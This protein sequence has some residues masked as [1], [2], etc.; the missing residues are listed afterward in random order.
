MKKLIFPL[1]IMVILSCLV[2]AQE[3][4]VNV[5]DFLE[6]E[7]LSFKY[8]S[9][10]VSNEVFKVGF[11]LMNSGSLDYRARVRL[12]IM[13]DT[14]L[15][16]TGWSEEVPLWP[17]QSEYFELYWYPVNI[18]G[19]LTGKI[20]IYH[21]NEIKEIEPFK[22]EIKGITT[23][24]K[25]IQITGLRTYEDRVEVSIR[26]NLELKDIIIIPSDYPYG[27]IFEQSKIDSIDENQEKRVELK[28]EPTIWKP[29][30]V[31]IHVFTED[32]EQYTSKSF[33]MERE[34]LFATV[35]SY[36]IK[37]FKTLS[38]FSLF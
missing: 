28:Y 26:S 25:D 8:S 37:I 13:D 32:G 15:Y 6:T 19:N 7:I 1:V 22:F 9:E 29:T 3:V 34:E 5:E 35:I 30:E 16:Y 14:D 21:A 24:K 18:T 38:F 17:G 33:L 27:W 31:V 2:R 11:E 12:N 23:P 10:L 20:R 36:F 4:K